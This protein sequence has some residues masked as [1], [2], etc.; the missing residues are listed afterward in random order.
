AVPAPVAY[1]V[2]MLLRPPS[3]CCRLRGQ[4]LRVAVRAAQAGRNPRTVRPRIGRKARRTRG[5]RPPLA[6][7]IR[8]PHALSRRDI[9][10]NVGRIAQAPQPAE[11]RLPP[12]RLRTR[13]E[14]IS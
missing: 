7:S 4:P 14:R 13:E 3:P 5:Q 1:D 8:M 6:D 2:P 9:R 12:D 11:P 10:N